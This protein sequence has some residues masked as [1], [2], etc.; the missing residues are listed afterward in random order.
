MAYFPKVQG[1]SWNPGVGLVGSESW[2]SF[3]LQPALLLVEQT[4]RMSLLVWVCSRHGCFSG[5]VVCAR[6]IQYDISYFQG[7]FNQSIDNK[8]V[9]EKV[10]LFN[11]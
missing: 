10:G 11:L 8:V 5:V 1:P 2:R 3:D 6:L 9:N 7:Y 4:I